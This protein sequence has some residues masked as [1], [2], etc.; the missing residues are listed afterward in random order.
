MAGPR[1]DELER[2]ILAK[3][4]DAAERMWLELLESDPGNVDGFL[5]AADG[6]TDRAGG[7]RQAGVLLWMV[8]GA[9]KDKGR[10]RDLVRLYARLAKIAPDDGT[11]RTA[12]TEAVRKG[13]AGR[14]DLEELLE[15]SG[16]VNGP[17]TEFAKQAETLERY[18]KLE[19]GAYVFHRTGW[20]IG[21]I[22]EYLPDRSRC[23]IDFVSKPKHGMDLL[24]AADLL[25]RLPED[26]LRVMAAFKQEEMRKVAKADPLGV[27]RRALVLLGGDAPLRHVKDL[28]VPVAIEKGEWAA[29]W[30]EARKAATIDPGFTIGPGS[31]P[32]LAYVAGG[33]ADFS[34]VLMRQL[35]FAKDRIARQNVI[36]EFVK[37]A[38]TDPG[39]R[40]A[41]AAVARTELARLSTAD[42]AG[43][44]SWTVILAQLEGRDPT[45]ALVP[46]FAGTQDPGAT[47]ALL[48]ADDARG[49]AARACLAARPAHG[50]H[51]VHAAARTQDCVI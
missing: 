30:K 17:A 43:R 12:L 5:K 47:L 51:V 35:S 15:R 9:L 27:L 18:L 32:R 2:A 11:L 31:D 6:I 40:E 1:W 29:W 7:R 8:A 36:R 48:D 23:V 44:L 38:G 42:P 49:L 50:D 16:V 39:A 37:T 3:D 13:Y 21:R 25:E 41:L 14:A 4:S 10:D 28:L 20:G 45:E 24:A 19:P 46:A 33:S 22:A 26:D 34:T